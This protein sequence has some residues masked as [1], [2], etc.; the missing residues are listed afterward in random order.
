MSFPR[1]IIR[2][3]LWSSLGGAAEHRYLVPRINISMPVQ[4]RQ[5]IGQRKREILCIQKDL[6]DLVQVQLKLR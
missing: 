2:R 4:D 5:S 3:T 6:L 1:G